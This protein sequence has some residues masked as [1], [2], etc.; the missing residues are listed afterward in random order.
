MKRYDVKKSQIDV[1]KKIKQKVPDPW[2][3]IKLER[4]WEREVV[5]Q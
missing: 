2:L 1:M 5:A 4:D 3:K